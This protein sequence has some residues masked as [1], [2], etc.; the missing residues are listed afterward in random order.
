MCCKTLFGAH[1]LHKSLKIQV[2][3]PDV[4]HSK[5]FNLLLPLII[6]FMSHCV[7]TNLVGRKLSAAKSAISKREPDCLGDNQWP[8]EGSAEPCSDFPTE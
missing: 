4:N 5:Y 6:L 2:F 1:L 8:T 3:P 7:E